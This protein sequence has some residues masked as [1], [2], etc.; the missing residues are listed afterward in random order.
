MDGSGESAVLHNVSSITDPSG[1]ITDP[2]RE[3]SDADVVVD[4]VGDVTEPF[5][6]LTDPGDLE[7]PK[8]VCTDP[9]CEKAPVKDVTITGTDT[10][11]PLL[12]ASTEPGGEI[13]KVFDD[14]IGVCGDATALSGDITEKD[15]GDVADLDEISDP[16][17]DNIELDGDVTEDGDLSIGHFNMASAYGFN[18]SINWGF[19]PDTVRFLFFNSAFNS[20]TFIS[21]KLVYCLG[22]PGV[23]LTEGLFTG[24][25]GVTG[26][27]FGFI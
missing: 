24:G 9:G 18:L 15:W 7:P 27:T 13:S 10:E 8:L 1:D 5:G 4:T 26:V 25:L 17:G 2:G 20:A 11:V 23:I 3:K 14:I 12:D 16:V 19:G 22:G 6:E 21:S